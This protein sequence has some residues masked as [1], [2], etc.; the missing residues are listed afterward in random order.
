MRRLALLAA[1]ACM[2][3]V[4]PAG[5]TRD[6][7]ATLCANAE[8]ASHCGRLIEQRQ[9]GRL[10]GLAV[11]E[12]DALR[13]TLYPSGSVTFTDVVRPEGVKTYALWDALSAID[14]VL[15]Y[16]T[17]GERTGFLLLD[18][19]NGRQLPL[20]AEPVLSP[21]RRYLVTADFCAEGCDGEVALWRV[22]RGDVRKERTWR[23]PARWTDATVEW[24]GTQRLTLEYATADGSA[25]R[26]MEL[27][28][29]DARWRPAP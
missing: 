14:S 24:Q 2:P 29:D 6:D 4:A 18:R 16:V 10:P 12:G 1:L 8:D 26:R 7:V 13:V 19:R 25:S 23:P 3:A 5:P 27:R 21:D 15:L 28:L 22:T 11:R 9:L 20:P 17:E